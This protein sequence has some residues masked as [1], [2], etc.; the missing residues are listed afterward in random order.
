M[1]PLETP[2]INGIVA[3]FMQGGAARMMA[4]PPSFA[5]AFAD[6]T[7]AP[8][9]LT[10]LTVPTRHGD[11]ACTVHRPASAKGAPALFVNFHG[12]GYVIALPEQDD[13]YCAFLAQKA[14]VIVVNVDYAV[15]PQAKFPVAIEQGVDVLNWLVANAREQGW[16]AKRIVIGGQSAGGA[17]AT[18]VART[19]RDAGSPTIAL[20]V[21][22]FPPLD[23][24]TQ[25]KDKP[26]PQPKPMLTPTLGHIFDAAY[27]PSSDRTNPLI[28]P[29][30][31]QNLALVGGKHPLAGM[32]RTLLTTAELDILR[33]EG[34]RYAKALTAAGVAVTYREFAGVDHGF[35]GME[36]VSTARE[37]MEL[38]AAEV[39]S[40]VG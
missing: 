25:A 38:V 17:I 28:S 26:H 32:P 9:A 23:L 15:A 4:A 13:L 31:V 7:V 11:V 29:A 8:T 21:L 10:A 22:N 16:D 33:E 2:V 19:A 40:A 34:A 5:T 30:A 1:H 24:V 6:V 35:L 3:R 14:G 39:T 18:A 27:A 36:P 37:A 12:G 20:Q